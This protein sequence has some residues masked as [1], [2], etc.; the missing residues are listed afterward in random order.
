LVKARE[1]A[2]IWHNKQEE[3]RLR[4]AEAEADK[5]LE[6]INLPHGSVS[7]LALAMLYLGE[8]FKKSLDTGIGNSDPT[9]L[10][11]FVA[12]LLN[13]YR[14]EKNKITCQ[15]HLRADQDPNMIKKYWS[16]KLGLPLAAFQA[17]S[18]DKRT[19][20]RPTYPDYKGVC[21]VR[22]GHVAI[23]RKLVYLSKKFCERIIGQ[24]QGLRA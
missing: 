8:G 11:F 9:I 17:V 24:N 4:L 19:K 23:Q 6:Q 20:G 3:N 16:E 7:E 2:V 22:C 14:V 21:I 1:K 13:F 5:T 12:M 18:Q 10:R 15:L